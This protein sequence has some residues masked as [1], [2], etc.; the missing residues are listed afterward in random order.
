MWLARLAPRGIDQPHC[1]DSKLAGEWHDL[2][3]HE[4]QLL[5]TYQMACTDSGGTA[6]QILKRIL[7]E[8]TLDVQLEN[9]VFTAIQC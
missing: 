2:R 8:W 4:D 1:Q 3:G 9:T 6:Q 5:L 7:L